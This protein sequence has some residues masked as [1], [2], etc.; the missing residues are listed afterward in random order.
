MALFRKK[1]TDEETPLGAPLALPGA[2]DDD[3]NGRRSLEDHRD[4]LLSLVKPLAPFGLSIGDSLGLELCEDVPSP[5]DV[6]RT[7][8]SVIDGFA[9]DSAVTTRAGNPYPVVLQVDRRPPS[10]VVQGTAVVVRAGDPLPAGVD[11][12]VPEESLDADG[13]V[14]LT[15]AV[16]PWSG[17]RLAG[18]DFAAGDPIVSRG[19]IL[20]PATIALLADSGAGKVLARPRPRV[21]VLGTGGG[22][23]GHDGVPLLDVTA[24]LISAATAETGAHVWRVEA[25]VSDTAAL[26]EAITDQLIRAD[27]LLITSNRPA[28]A[29]RDPVADLLPDLGATDFCQVA[30]DPGA[31]QGFG[32]VGPDLVPVMVMPPGPGAALVSFHAFAAPL[33][34]KLGGITVTARQTV[35][36]EALDILAG[37]DTPVRFVP[38]VL[39]DRGG[40]SCA[41]RAGRGD[42]RELV[43]LSEADAFA[44]IPA[45][46]GVDVG[47]TVTCWA[48][49]RD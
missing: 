40:R 42:A 20:H 14:S 39:R 45:G 46:Q 10:P 16:H 15:A 29:R 44:V 49:E 41:A 1:K 17:C 18:S 37:P 19:R 48:V 12:V 26:R 36:A 2:P 8:T 34:R 13:Q 32:L 6:P 28:A 24:H 23:S 11:C 5:V 47:D 25:D 22:K 33:L 7:T 4:F 31:T 43:D 27:L 35:E 9:L 38:V 3:E 21:V 30:M